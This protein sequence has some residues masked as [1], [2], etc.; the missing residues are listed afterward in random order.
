LL[1][2]RHPRLIYS[3][4]ASAERGQALYDKAIAAGCEGTVS[5]RADSRYSSSDTSQW[6][7]VT[8]AEVREREAAAIR[9]GFE[10]TARRRGIK[11]GDD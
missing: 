11:T 1:R 2:A 9:A 10:R 5:K 4:H 6:I 8:P 7:K 3:E